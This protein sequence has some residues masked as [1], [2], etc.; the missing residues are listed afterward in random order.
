MRIAID[1][2]GVLSKY[3]WEIKSIIKAM[4]DAGHIVY[5]LTDMDRGSASLVLEE[6]QIVPHLVKSDAVLCADF[7]RHGEAAKAVVVREQMIDVLI[8]DHPGYLVWPW[9][10][11]APLRLAVMPDP[12]RAYNSNSWISSGEFGR[13]WYRGEEGGD[14]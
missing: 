4:S 7:H 1:I 8:D 5:L 2:G 12:R 14:K 9:D 10:S 11:M 3:P 13:A 6:N